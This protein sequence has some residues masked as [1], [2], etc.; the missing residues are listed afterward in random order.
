MAGS[1]GKAALTLVANSGPL[2]NDLN[3]AGADIK[4]W[5]GG[6]GSRVGGA[7]GAIGK[8]APALFVAQMAVNAL[9]NAFHELMSSISEIDGIAKQAK[10]IGL[11]PS[12]LQALGNAARKEGMEFAQF[13]TLFEKF[14][15]KIAQGSPEVAAALSSI[16]LN[17]QDL[18]NSTAKDAFLSVADGLARTSDSGERAAAAMKIFEEQGLRLLPMLSQGRAGLQAFM[19]EQVR[20]GQVLSGSQFAAAQVAQG[21]YEDATA[22]ISIAWQKVVA[23]MSPVLTTVADIVSSV[24]EFLSPAFVAF[25][26]FAVDALKV[27][28]KMW[29]YTWDTIKLGAGVISGLWGA[30]AK[31]FENV[32]YG[33]KNIVSVATY[34]PDW[35]GGGL[36]TDAV[37]IMQ[38]VEDEFASMSRGAMEFAARQAGAFGN[39]AAEIDAYFDA[40]GRKRDEIVRGAN[41]ADKIG[42]LDKAGGA[43]GLSGKSGSASMEAILRGSK[44]DYTLRMAFTD[45]MKGNEEKLLGEA[46]KANDLAKEANRHLATLTKRGED[47]ILGEF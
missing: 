28:L 40:I 43:S 26:E 18:Q 21:A 31:Y 19:D 35:L 23:A 14:T 13:G 9:K 34:L 44:E 12:D 16:G 37:A 33:M 4:G 29:A 46:K 17:L 5:A 22:A 7:L 15:G 3:K 8:A 27:W 11:K 24:V 10:V 42:A 30:V 45:R 47:R 2:K 6:V 32:T 39:S 25:A 41:V 38:G 36:A 20:S 1:I